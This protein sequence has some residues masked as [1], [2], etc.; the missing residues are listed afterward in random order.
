MLEQPLLDIL[1]QNQEWKK[2]TDLSSSVLINNPAVDTWRSLT[3]SLQSSGLVESLNI[4]KGLYPS[5]LANWLPE[6]RTIRGNP[7][8]WD[9]FTDLFP[10]QIS[11]ADSLN[12]T[13]K[14][15]DIPGP[16]RSIQSS[17]YDLSGKVS[18]MAFRMG[19]TSWLDAFEQVNV[20]AKAV[21]DEAAAHAAVTKEDLNNLQEFVSQSIDSIK[22]EIQ[23]GAKSPMVII[24]FFI[25]LISL[26][27]T[28]WPMIAD[29]FKAPGEQNATKHDIE[30][31]RDAIVSS[32]N[33]ELAVWTE[34]SEIRVTCAVR[35]K[36]SS[37]SL[38]LQSL[39]KG[40]IVTI[41]N[42]SHKWVNISY[43][44]KNNWP[45]TGWV[46]KKYLNPP[47]AQA[48]APKA[49]RLIKVDK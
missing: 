48:Q 30:L 22:A 20:Q 28:A 5:S 42:T 11:L 16:L 47:T 46:L 23:K 27:L 7:L 17:L 13:L 31:V 41:I 24:S 36:P 25:G 3:S 18:S 43:I 32:Y 1:K 2:L 39:K 29:K 35:E 21:V 10:K 4:A 49:L 33:A 45:V 34:K 14:G 15:I 26:V 38:V 40:C 8:L 12:Q 19:D 37:H 6:P 9:R 44:D